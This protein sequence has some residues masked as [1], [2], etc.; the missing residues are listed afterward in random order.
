VRRDL[1]RPGRPRSARPG[2]H[3]PWRVPSAAAAGRSPRRG[4]STRSSAAPRNARTGLADDTRAQH[5]PG[6]T[7]G[8]DALTSTAPRSRTSKRL[9]TSR[10][11][12]APITTVSG[13]ARACSRAARLGS[14]RRP[15]F[16][17]QALPIRSSDDHQSGGNAVRA[18][19]LTELTSRRH[20]A[21]DHASPARTPARHHPMGSR[22][23]NRSD[24]V[25]HVFR[26]K[27]IEISDDISG[28]SGDI[29]R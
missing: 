17:R 12:P 14:R 25:A 7:G 9:P 18:W 22:Y 6:R 23:R 28:R 3:P 16:L 19:S 4:R 10:R 24:A 5:L 29:Q 2:R 15:M 21:S 1:P 11:V 27:A 26:N 20:T 8:S 13:S